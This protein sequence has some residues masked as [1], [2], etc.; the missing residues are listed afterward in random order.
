M[1][2]SIDC[3]DSRFRISRPRAALAALQAANRDRPLFDF[4]ALP[5]EVQA[6]RTVVEALEACWWEV[7]ADEKGHVSGLFYEGKLLTSLEDVER[8]FATLAP[9]VRAGSYLA[10]HGEDGARW[11]YV[12]KNRRLRVDVDDDERE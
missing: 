12:F 10:I 5:A 3:R 1:G 11:R 7:E 8:L 9:F 2:Y 4:E 6:A